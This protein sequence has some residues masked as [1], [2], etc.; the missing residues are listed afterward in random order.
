M[1]V[2][3]PICS[4]LPSTNQRCTNTPFAQ[5]P[6][7]TAVGI[8]PTVP[9]VPASSHTAK[10]EFGYVQNRL[11]KTS[12]D[13]AA[14]VGSSILSRLTLGPKTSG[15]IFPPCSSRNEYRDSQRSGTR[16]I[17]SNH[18]LD[19]AKFRH[20]GWTHLQWKLLKDSI[21]RPLPISEDSHSP[22]N[23]RIII[24]TFPP[25]SVGMYSPPH[26]VSTP[27][28]GNTT[29]HPPQDLGS[30]TF[31]T[32]QS[33]NMPCANMSH[34]QDAGDYGLA[35]DASG[36]Y[37]APE[38]LSVPSP[39]NMNSS[40]F[41]NNNAFNNESYKHIDPASMIGS[42]PN[43]FR[44]SQTMFG[45]NDGGM[46]LLQPDDPEWTG[47][48]SSSGFNRQMDSSSL[49]PTVDWNFVESEFTTST[50]PIFS[51]S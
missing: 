9:Y 22:L 19:Q 43:S 49:A 16:T 4:H 26:S 33:R 34:T 50:K 1:Q 30:E 37:S 10:K 3:P 35:F 29:P 45:F 44:S 24:T 18:L 25:T 14:M 42:L 21:T 48:R 15:R 46:E 7:E 2:D 20:L 40:D 28:S 13:V 38:S 31:F 11:R 51:W 32:F 36:L 5:P 8:A 27:Q 41:L 23:F 6:M 39:F 12:M 17:H 47:A